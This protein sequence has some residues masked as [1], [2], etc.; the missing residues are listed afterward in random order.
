MALSPREARAASAPYRV[1]GT[2]EVATLEGLAEAL[3]P[4]A[5]VAG[6]SHFIDA[7]L[8][9]AGED[10]LLMLKYLGVPPAD[11]TGFYRDG[12]NS[13]ERLAQTRFSRAWPA[14]SA[15]QADSLLT[16]MNDDV[17]PEWNGPPAAFFLFVVRSDACDVVYGT[18]AGFAGLNTPYMAHIEP[19]A[20]W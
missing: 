9:A 4:G 1:L 14:L 5:R 20:P 13:V 18:P 2:D 17:G 16:A 6:I 19:T 15:A 7:Q 12:L 3:V 8:A 10:C 11:F